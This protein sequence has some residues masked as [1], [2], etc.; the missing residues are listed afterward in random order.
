MAERTKGKKRQLGHRD[1]LRTRLAA[2]LI[3]GREL[4]A[5]Q[6]IAE[7]YHGISPSSFHKTFKRDRDALAAQGI[8]L[9]E[10]TSGTAKRWRIDASLSLADLGSLSDED[11]LLLANL[12]E[13]LVR[14]RMTSRPQELGQAVARLGRCAPGMSAA[15]DE[16]PCNRSVLAAVTSSLAARTPCELLYQSLSDP[17][18][19]W[20][21]LRPYGLFELNEAI[22][23]VGLREREGSEPAMR[24][25]NL[26]RAHEVRPRT[27]LPSFEVPSS[28]SLGAYRLLPFE[29]GPETAREAHFYVPRSVAPT[30]RE[31]VGERGRAV[32]KQGGSME[33]H[34]FIKDTPR[35][36]SW[37]VEVG[38]IPLEPRELV[39]A[40]TNLLEGAER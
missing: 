5:E 39:D 32:P 20:R 25:L 36:A 33:W 38:A 19:V 37:A 21:L 3:S 35:A 8:H 17:T 13:P 29:L 1:V 30:F 16:P 14:E 6:L 24:T 12:L 31:E 9:T 7:H 27:D 23:V 40:W 11:A 4:G 22:Y 15:R 10:S 34:A 28:F 18:P 26:S 2:E